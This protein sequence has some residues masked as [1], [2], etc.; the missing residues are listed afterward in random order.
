MKIYLKLILVPT[1]L[2]SLFAQA[3][4]EVKPESFSVSPYVAGYSFLGR[5]R[6]ETGPAAGLRGGYNFTSHF[7]LEAVLTYIS[8]EGKAYSG[9]GD[10]DALNYHLDM[11]YHFMP[12]NTLVPYLAMGFGGHWRDYEGD[13]EVNRAAFNYGGG[14]K[15]FLT[16]AMAL[17][18]DVRHIVMRDHDETFH[19][20]EYGIG[21]DFVFGGRKAAPAVAAAAPVAA[22]VAQPPAEEAP[23]EP[24]P[25]AEPAPGHYKYCVTLQGEFDI[26]KADI[27]PE[28]RDEIATVGNFMKQYPTTTAVIEGHTDNVGNSEYNLGLSKRRAQAVVDYLVD[29][30]GIE[31]SRLEARGFGMSRPI[32]T[33]STDEGRQANRRIEAIIDC[34]FDVKE[35]QPPDRLCMTLLLEFDSGKADI[36]P[37]YRGEMAKVGEYMNK[38]PTTTAVIEGHTDN[39]GGYDYNMKLSQQRADNAV[40]YL[41]QNFGIDK[42]RLSAKGYGYTR[43]IAYNSTAEGR[44][45]NRRINAVID[46]VIKK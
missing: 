18:G 9:I 5:D 27:R 3:Y 36:K 2:L 1:L 28:Y 37:Q 23:L 19:N 38:Y 39:V 13:G 41:V 8:T 35:V 45:K 24:V 21:V 46:C 15:Y 25:A 44:A 7:G 40:Q 16:D 42:S 22:P 12:E 34:A 4:A 14:V 33:N 30:Y 31:R 26:D 10:V 20:L 32:A 17:R 43:R 11:L 29:N 6:L